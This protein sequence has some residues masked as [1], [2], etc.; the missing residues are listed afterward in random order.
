[1]AKAGL[2]LGVK[3]TR[4]LLERRTDFGPNG[5]DKLF[6]GVNIMVAQM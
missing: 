1:M 6:P 5:W 2:D 3:V 4:F